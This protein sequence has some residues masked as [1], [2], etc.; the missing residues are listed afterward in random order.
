M[1]QALVNI[2]GAG[3]A[4]CALAMLVQVWLWI[5]LARLGLRVQKA[6]AGR[7]EHIAQARATALAIVRENRQEIA[8]IRIAANDVVTI[9]RKE[10]A[11]VN[12]VAREAGRRYVIER[13]RIR[14]VSQDMKQRAARTSR[15]FEAGIEEPWRD[16]LD[17]LRGM[18]TGY[19][20][21]AR[22]RDGATPRE[23]SAPHA[24]RPAA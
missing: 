4:V 5:A 13:E 16:V 9:T 15:V 7:K 23:Q 21:A 12:H 10:V 18:A 6:L 19:R 3:V 24:H 20:E 1:H 22:P 17:F 2:I 14:M 11:V 8:H